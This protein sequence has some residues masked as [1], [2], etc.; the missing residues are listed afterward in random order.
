MFVACRGI[1]VLVSFLEADYAKYRYVNIIL[2][3]WSIYSNYRHI[4]SQRK[5]INYRHR[6]GLTS[7]WGFLAVLGVDVFES[8]IQ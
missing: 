7:G 6:P 8:L 5:K 3:Q 1:P 4:P 2:Q